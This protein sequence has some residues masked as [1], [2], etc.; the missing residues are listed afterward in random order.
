M[1]GVRVR[2]SGRLPT[3]LLVAA[4]L[5]LLLMILAVGTA[6]GASTGQLTSPAISPN[7]AVVGQT[8]SFGV[9]YTD[10]SGLA[11]V[12]VAVRIDGTSVPMSGAG[13][14]YA[15]GVRFSAAATPALGW[16]SIYF[17][18][19][20]AGTNT[21]SLH[22]TSLHIVSADPSPT[23]TPTPT[24]TPK[25]SATP[26][27]KPT[28]TPTPPPSS[29][30]TH[31]PSPT[32]PPTT[33]PTGSSRGTGSS[34]TATPAPA[35]STGGTGPTGGTG[36]HAGA[37]GSSTGV[38]T[39]THKPS[40]SAAAGVGAVGSAAP[41]VDGQTT[42]TAGAAIDP[43]AKI[44]GGDVYT[45]AISGYEATRGAYGGGF[46]YGLPAGPYG[47][48]NPTLGQ[49][50]FK[51]AP[52]IA[53]ASAGGAAWAAFAF[54]GKRRRDEQEMDET[55]LATAAATVYEVEAAPGLR[56]VDES[57]L[58]R[59]RRPSLQ[60]VRRTDPLRAVAD[61]SHLSF[62]AAGVRPLADYERRYIGYRLVRLLD[63][64]DEFRSQEIGI[65]D[66]GDE[67][68]LLERHG[69]YWLVLCPDGRQ[70]WVHRMTLAEPVVP[71][72]SAIEP[73]PMPQYM[74]DDIV[75]EMADPANELSAEGLLEAYMKARGEID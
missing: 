3:S 53:M 11:P 73:E 46:P 47:L 72:I 17:V 7:P 42:G 55:L 35:G 6:A 65:L 66:Q 71:D 25:P 31:T 75:M 70:G 27:P 49:L 5:A 56:V 21:I 54:F 1:T 59:W 10:S 2:R 63:S 34:P 32:S 64:P 48:A 40:P 44:R 39:P 30:A 60:Q 52:T 28:L 58:P 67:V 26:T 41:G 37:T 13:S 22:A 51:L 14:D 43:M 33:S 24:P 50:L 57:L 16:H 61:V 8:V 4:P 12:S 62:E 69:V 15:H 18:A 45:G 29:G 68:Q 36:T 19:I 38:S 20:D 23:P 9:T 74:D